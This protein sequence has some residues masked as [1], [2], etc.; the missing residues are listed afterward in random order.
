MIHT[1]YKTINLINQK[2]YMG[3]HTTDDPHDSYL[4]SGKQLQAAIRKHGRDNFQK[5]VMA[6]FDTEDQM[7]AFE[8]QVVDA[9]NVASQQCYNITLGGGKPPSW[10]GRKHSAA[11]KVGMSGDNNPMRRPEVAAHHCRINKGKKKPYLTERN[12]GNQY[13]KGCVRSPETK[14]KMA[15]SAR[16]ARARR[17]AA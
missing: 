5:E 11:K 13:S 17:K 7:I 15:A 2:F 8:A 10:K 14:A 12:K 3:L 4:G 16:A 6:V 1:V 9:A